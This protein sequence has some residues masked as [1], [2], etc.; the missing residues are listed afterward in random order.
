M[1]KKQT[2]T[3]HTQASAQCD[4]HLYNLSI[5]DELCAHLKQVC[6]IYL[7]ATLVD[8]QNDRCG[9]P[10]LT[11]LIAHT[12][13]LQL[14]HGSDEWVQALAAFIRFDFWPQF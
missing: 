2:T 13:V 3:P 8:W 6:S 9:S 7:D 11:W 14:V 5:Y 12:P 10:P 1:I 4:L